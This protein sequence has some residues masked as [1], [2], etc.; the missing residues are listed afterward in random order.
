MSENLT[1][2]FLKQI[3]ATIHKKN[4]ISLVKRLGKMNKKKPCVFYYLKKSEATQGR[5]TFKRAKYIVIYSH[6][7]LAIN[8]SAFKLFVS[9]KASKD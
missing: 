8:C 5:N 6:G 2:L 7:H 4:Q 9:F 3:S 1:Y